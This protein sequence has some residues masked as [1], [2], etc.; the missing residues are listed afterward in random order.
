M[1]KMYLGI[2]G[3][4]IVF[5][6]RLGEKS[7]APAIRL[8]E[9]YFKPFHITPQPNDTIDYEIEFVSRDINPDENNPQ[10]IK[11]KNS[12]YIK[13]CSE[14]VHK[15]K[16]SALFPIGLYEIELMLRM[17]FFEILPQ[18]HSFC[19]HASA[20]ISP[21]GGAYLFLGD[22][23]AGKSTIIRMIGKSFKPLLDDIG[24]IRKKGRGYYL[25]TSPYKEKNTYTKVPGPF[26]IEKIFFP[27]KGERFSIRSIPTVNIVNIIKRLD[28][29]ILV[30]TNRKDILR[31][32]STYSTHLF[33]IYF[34]KFDKHLGN[35]VK[36]YFM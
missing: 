23:G 34:S 17:I 3:F 15:K 32:I 16:I 26:L 8:I 2:A 14:D 11:I 29:Q 30:N 4:T 5:L 27:M 25:Y 10:S 28:K 6:F 31:F 35:K 12:V 22:S 1:K 21:S 18:S 7:Y 33:E 13:L 20:I 36:R 9:N 24:F 19:I